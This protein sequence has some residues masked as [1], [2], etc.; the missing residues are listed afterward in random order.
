[1]TIQD[2]DNRDDLDLITNSQDVK[3]FCE[4]TGRPYDEGMGL[5]IKIVDGEIEEL[6]SFAGEI[7]YLYKQLEKLI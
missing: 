2:I 4:R 3:F 7:P 5:F 1:M 6:Y